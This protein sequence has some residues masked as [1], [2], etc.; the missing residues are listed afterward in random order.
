[1]PSRREGRA[2]AR[3]S[4]LHDAVAAEGEKEGKEHQRG[5][6]DVARRHEAEAE[7]EPAHAPLLREPPHH[8]A[9]ESAEE[10]RDHVEEPH[11][12]RTVLRRDDI[13]ERGV[14]VHLEEATEDADLIIVYK[15]EEKINLARY[16]YL[17]ARMEPGEKALDESKK[18]YQEFSQ[19]MYQWML[20]E[21]A[22]KQAITALYIYV[23]TIR[24]T[25]EGE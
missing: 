17:L 13:E 10:E 15:D 9:G 21:K 12:R 4:P 11:G 7:L 5:R 19:K 23:Y 20:D 3:P 1:M 16:A 18:L 8:N 2:P 25:A 24:E 14:R 6:K 22:C